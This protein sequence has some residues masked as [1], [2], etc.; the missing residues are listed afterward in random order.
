MWYSPGFPHVG[1]HSKL[2]ISVMHMDSDE[3]EAASITA[4]SPFAAVH[5][6]RKGFQK[7]IALS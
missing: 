5:D 7:L 3:P 4:C 6:L 2:L 1:D